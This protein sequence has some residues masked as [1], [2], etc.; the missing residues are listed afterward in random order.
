MRDGIAAWAIGWLLSLMLPLTWGAE[1]P[2]DEEVDATG[3]L[4]TPSVQMDAAQRA[5]IGQA[6][7]REPLQDLGEGGI[8]CRDCPAY[9]AD[10]SQDEGLSINNLIHGQFT[11]PGADELLLDTDGCESHADGF[12]GGCSISPPCAWTIAGWS[13][14]RV[15]TGWCVTSTMPGKGPCS[16]PFPRC[17]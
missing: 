14:G 15:A 17:G 5:A 8:G 12:G 4:I 3:R 9:T 11:A 1:I 13:L 2:S 16:V 7:C 10:P 6:V